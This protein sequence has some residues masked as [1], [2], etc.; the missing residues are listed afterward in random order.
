MRK[1]LD[2]RPAIKK[3]LIICVA[4]F[5][6]FALV[7]MLQD[8]DFVLAGKYVGISLLLVALARI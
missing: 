1:L 5:W 4:V 8:A 7:G 3:V 2:A 6:T